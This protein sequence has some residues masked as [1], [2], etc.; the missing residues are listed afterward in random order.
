MP[1]GASD[2][3]DEN[4][5]RWFLGMDTNRDGEVG[6]QEFL[7]TADRFVTLDK[8]GDGFINPAELPR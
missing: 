7:G 5:P 3:P 6:I 2:L 1:T 8:N 4:L